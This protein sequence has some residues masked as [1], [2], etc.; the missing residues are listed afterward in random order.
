MEVDIKKYVIEAVYLTVI[1][2]VYII[3]VMKEVYINKS[4]IVVCI[5]INK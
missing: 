5:S 2:E 4:I 3:K 1:R